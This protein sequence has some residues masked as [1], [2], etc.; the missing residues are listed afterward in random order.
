LLSACVSGV[1]PRKD[2]IPIIEKADFEVTVLAEDKK[3]SERQY[4]EIALEG[5]KLVTM[6]LQNSSFIIANIFSCI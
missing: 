3:I 5:L 6:K 4:H 1:L 2:Y